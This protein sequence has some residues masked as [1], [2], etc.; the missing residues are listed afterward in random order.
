MSQSLMLIG[1]ATCGEYKD[2]GLGTNDSFI[3]EGCLRYKRLDAIRHAG[4]KKRTFILS[5]YLK[6]FFFY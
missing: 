1:A 2:N 5:K 3:P 4:N 6:L